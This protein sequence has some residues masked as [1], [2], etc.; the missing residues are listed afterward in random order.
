MVT[1]L[2]FT[3]AVFVGVFLGLIVFLRRI[4]NGKWPAKRPIVTIVQ[5]PNTTCLIISSP[6]TEAVDK[7]GKVTGVN[8]D[9]GPFVR[10][11]H[12]VD[13]KYLNESDPDPMNHKLVIE[14]PET[15]RVE[16]RDL[17][18][19]PFGLQFIWFFRYVEISSI[20]KTRW[21]RRDD[22]TEYSLQAKTSHSMF[23]DFS[24]QHDIKMDGVET[25]KVLK[26]NIRLNFTIEETYP[27]RARKRTADS[28]AQ[29]TIMVNDHVV[30]MMGRVD[31]TE[32]IGGKEEQ[33]TAKD[34]LKK[35]LIASFSER[36]VW[37]RI[38]EE[39][40]LTIRKASFPEFDFDENTR[41]LL[42][43]A[44]KAELEGEAE[45]I[46]AKK[47][48]E[49]ELQRIEADAKRVQDVTIPAAK[50]ER[51]VQVRWAEAYEENK[52]LTTLVTGGSGVTPVI[53][54]G[55]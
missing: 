19:N 25:G 52:T 55:K 2:L 30:Y 9:G 15:G 29:F 8:N 10:I 7:D 27:Y 45:V 6:N 24:G 28:Y 12:T 42:E 14:D 38:E 16:R 11:L 18:Y 32:F 13:G 21:G 34:N 31:P 40:G 41:K 5:P 17:F 47:A 3:V 36:E 33:E 37:E 26:F 1:F 4:G 51:T 44:I 20:R 53:P 35:K 43:A 46:R 23:P 39:T 54:L 50:D 22:Q 48:K 49:A